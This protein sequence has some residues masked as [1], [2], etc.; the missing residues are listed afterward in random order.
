[1]ANAARHQASPRI[2]ICG[3]GRHGCEA[4]VIAHQLG[5]TVV[6]VYN[7]AGPK[8]GQDVGMLSAHE[9]KIGIAVEDI[10]GVDFNRLN[11]DLAIVAVSDRLQQNLPIYERL[12]SAGINIICHGS[13]AYYPQG[14][15]PDAAKIIDRLATA[16][17]VSF[18]GTGV[19]D[20]SRIWAGIL[21]AGPC[22]SIRSLKHRS[23][24]RIDVHPYIDMVGIGLS[25][26]DFEAAITNQPGPLGGIY[27]TIPNLVMHGLGYEVTSVIER[28]EPVLFD[29]PVYCVG[30]ERD[31]QPGECAGTRI[32]VEIESTQGVTA[33]AEIELRV[34]E[35]GEVDN[36]QW[37]IDGDPSSD[38][39]MTR[40]DSLRTST[41][42]MINRVADV[43]AAPP[44]IQ[45]ITNLGPLNSRATR[46][47]KE[48]WKSE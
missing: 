1:L 15:N 48:N 47:L 23:R 4:A 18:T 33:R 20:H 46:K 28:R 34:F 39:L 24:T 36:M 13:E 6:G 25:Q 16:N 37:I 10:D 30:L 21:A 12:L 38:V 7:R 14:T 42:V 44:G 27:R 40:H 35:A 26:H 45:L 17:G 11:A 5:W 8:V 19:W 41:M 32:V 3:A 43:I 22:G 29:H 9:S 31:L 2:L